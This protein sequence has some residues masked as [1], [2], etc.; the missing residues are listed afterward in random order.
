MHI[1]ANSIAKIV[2]TAT[3]TFLSAH[4]APCMCI[5]LRFDFPVSWQWPWVLG[6]MVPCLMSYA[7]FIVAFVVSPV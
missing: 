4:F 6:V 7:A 3:L 1:K 2:L 5:N